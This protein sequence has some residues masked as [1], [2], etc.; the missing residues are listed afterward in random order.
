MT[1]SEAFPTCEFIGIE[2]NDKMRD[3]ANTCLN[4]LNA[5]VISGDIRNSL[6]FPAKTFDLVICQRVLINILN[7]VDQKEGT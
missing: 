3:V 6:T 7:P 5:R 4:S 1:M 2:Q